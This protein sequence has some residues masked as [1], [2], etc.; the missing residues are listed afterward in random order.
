MFKIL[1][2]FFLFC[3]PENRK[4][5]RTSIVFGVFKALADAFKI[6]AIAILIKAILTGSVTSA[7][8]WTTLI[9]MVISIVVSALING[10]ATMLQTEGGYGTCAVKRMEIAKHMRYLPMGYFN[11]NSLGEITSVTTNTMQNLE[12][13]ATRVVLLVLGGLLSAAMVTLMLFFFDYRIA[14]ILLVVL[15]VY[16]LVNQKMMQFSN[17]ISPKKD[18]TDASLIAEIIEYLEGITEVKTYGITGIHSKKLNA[19]LKENETINTGMELGFVPYMGL[20]SF[21]L[22]CSGIAMTFASIL[23][24]LNGTMELYVTIV[25]MISS[26]IIY[27]S[28]E[29]AGSF[30]A[31]LRT[32]EICIDKANA[33]LNTPQMDIDGKEIVPEHYDIQAEHISF[34]YED[35]TIIDDITL[36]VPEKKVTA[37]VG[38]SGGGKTT[39][40]TLLARFFDVNQ[41]TVTLDGKDVR[42]YSMDSLMK[43]YSFVF[44]DVYLFNDTIANNIRFGNPNATMEDVQEAAKKACCHDFIMRLPE[45]YDTLL[46]ENG[47]NLSG[48]ERQ[49]I[50]IARAIMKDAPI[51]VLDEATANVDPENEKDLMDAIDS[52][53]REKTIIM[54]AHRLKTVEHADQ[55]IVID[56]GTI[57]E[58]GT[59]E[60]LL[61]EDGI[62]SR[63]IQSRKQ[64]TSWKIAA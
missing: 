46:S 1:H 33:I 50:S 37:F 49:R 11:E 6:P 7:T 29:T 30:S 53:T 36:T 13:V 24:Y 40:S 35:K 59:H 64:A 56:H 23:F 3:S 47:S 32:V 18:A 34:A 17:V 12:N 21:L 45:G 2:K 9:I 42:D 44:Q 27:A 58:R 8:V 39:L 43:N 41:G 16:Y 15:F 52:L 25:M 63:F 61:K 57:A 28:L 62:Y 5:F 54:I 14:L 10:K 26:Y 55:I 38:P 31:L 48:G 4:K 22:K 19:L 51:I 20:Q 60:A